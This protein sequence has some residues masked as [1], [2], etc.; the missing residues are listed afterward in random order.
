MDSVLAR[1]GRAFPRFR[2]AV[3]R[4]W[5]SRVQLTP[6]ARAPSFRTPPK[7]FSYSY[8]YA[9]SYSSPLRLYRS[10][11]DW[12]ARPFLAQAPGGT[13]ADQTDHPDGE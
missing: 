8:S 7:P 11:P 1:K 6:S 12:K 5:S 4:E 2:K 10:S 13:A 3:S 9:Y